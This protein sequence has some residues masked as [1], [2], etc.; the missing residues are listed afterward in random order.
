MP[1]YNLAGRIAPNIKTV[2]E[3]MRES[4][5]DFEVVAVDDGSGDDTSRE[6]MGLAAEMPR[7]KHAQLKVNAGK[8]AALKRGFQASRGHFVLFLDAD[9]DLPVDQASSFFSTMES[10]KADIVIG[11]K[12]HPD[13]KLSYPLHRRIMSRT[14]FALVKAMIGLPVRDTQTGIKLFRREALDA[15]FPRMLVK[16]Y[17]FDL[18]LLSIAHDFGFKIAEAP[19]TLDFQARSYPFST[20]AIV[21]VAIDTL[22]IFYRTKILRYYK[23]IPVQSM[24]APPPL[25]S[26]VIACPAYS[27]YLEECIQ[28][29]LLQTYGRFEVL[30]LPDGPTGRT[31]P[32]ARIREIPTGAIR[33]A[34]KRN[35]GIKEA[36]GDICAFLDDDA[37]PAEDWLQN[38]ALYFSS[39]EVGAAGGPAVTPPNDPM[40]AQVSGDVFANPLVSG[41]YRYRYTSGR[42]RD[43]EDFPSCNLIVKTSTLR[44]LNGFRTD[45]WPG[46]DTF[47]CMDIVLKCGRK[48]VYDPRILVY[49]H[50]RKVFLPHLRQV[51]RYALHRG[52]FAR[53]FPATSRK[54]SYFVPSLFVAG[55]ISGA[56]ASWF[57]PALRPAY[58]ASILAY[59]VITLVFSFSL[60]PVRWLLGWLG[61]M[62]THAVYGIRFAIGILS[63]QMPETKALF[64]H[65][66]E[67]Q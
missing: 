26:V 8:G 16:Q 50:R 18:E 21:R 3:V 49:H 1:A 20:R 24:P 58:L 40:L 66:S 13:S 30:I 52:Y 34:E 56:A 65:P 22:A 57:I 28:A 62:A 4:G 32:D 53:K 33:P 43:V 61:T 9:L 27:G 67:N 15:S 6:I 7:V 11:C 44:D 42:V 41:G 60:N 23:S 37:F 38:A 36:R 64:D 51:G 31:W 55:V 2:H 54:L 17:A 29:V 19:V 35:T 47:L 25:I 5:L 10:E 14:Y 59:S 39:E 46:E 63:R 45:F 48:I 12:M